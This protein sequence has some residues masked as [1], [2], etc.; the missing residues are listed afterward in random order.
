DEVL[1]G[2]DNRF[3]LLT[4]GYRTALPRHQTLR[5]LIDWSWSLLSADE[6][7]AL[8]RLAVFPAGIDT[9]DAADVAAT[10]GLVGASVFESLVD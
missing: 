7:T 5:A 1:D 9:R 2:L 8:G 4:G 3:T 6:R 10:A